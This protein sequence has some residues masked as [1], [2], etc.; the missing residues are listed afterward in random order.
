MVKK[1]LTLSR[2]IDQRL[3]TLYIAHIM[4]RN[5]D[6]ILF[7]DRVKASLACNI[8][9]P[10]GSLTIHAPPL[11]YLS[12]LQFA[13]PLHLIEP[14]EGHRFEERIVEKTFWLVLSFV[15]FTPK[16]GFLTSSLRNNCKSFMSSSVE[17]R[18]APFLYCPQL[19][20][21]WSSS[22]FCTISFSIRSNIYVTFCSIDSPDLV[23][24]TLIFAKS[25]KYW[26]G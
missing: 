17:N 21:N 12:F 7:Y 11:Y 18:V 23:V 10:E 6:V 20:R 25:I 3:W 19:P 5:S 16:P 15:Q 24:E 4:L 1:S 22:S 26:A 9:W 8:T 2:N 13:L 14:W